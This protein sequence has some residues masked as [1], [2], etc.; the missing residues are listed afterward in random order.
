[1]SSLRNIENNHDE[2]R[3]KDCMKKCCQLRRQ[4]MRIITFKKKKTK[5]LT[6]EQWEPYKNEK[7]NYICKEKIDN[8][9][10]KNKKLLSS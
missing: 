2:H 9:Y 7:K 1:M 6:K 8:K 4:A 3:G 10:L 5:L